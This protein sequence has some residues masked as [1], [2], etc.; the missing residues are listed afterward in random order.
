MRSLS[1]LN[2]RSKALRERLLELSQRCGALHLAPAF[3][4]LE[5]VDLVYREFMPRFSNSDFIMSKGHGYL[6]QLVVLESLD[7]IPH[8]LLDSIGSDGS[9]YGGHP[10]RGTP[11]VI[12]STGSLGHGLGMAVG[13]SISKS[14]KADDTN[15]NISSATVVLISDGELQEGSTWENII[16]SVSLR[17]QNLLLI[18]DNNDMQTVGTMSVT[19]P[20]MYPIEEKLSQFGWQTAVVD[21]HDIIGIS[22]SLRQIQD[23][24]GCFALV[25][26]TIKGKG[27]SFM[28]SS[29]IWHYRSP[30]TEEYSVALQELGVKK[31]ER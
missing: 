3:S 10:D 12:A 23:N 31:H 16:N 13:L 6:A 14:L 25:A 20:K 7:Q 24:F 22:N 8:G 29:S 5:L 9:L 15:H 21:G 30:N 17:A 2:L 26:K 1:N 19:H 4:C 28:E 27:V 11:G 18:I